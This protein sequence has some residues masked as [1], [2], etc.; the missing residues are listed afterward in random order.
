MIILEREHAR[1]VEF[2]PP[3]SPLLCERGSRWNLREVQQNVPL[4]SEEVEKVGYALGGET[5]A[6]PRARRS[7]RRPRLT[8]S[9]GN[10]TQQGN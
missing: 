6:D 1:E 7:S 10:I 8:T 2:E 5:S 4:D 3:C 9:L